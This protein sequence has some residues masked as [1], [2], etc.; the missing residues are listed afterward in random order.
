MLLFKKYSLRAFLSIMLLL[1]VNTSMLAGFS[2]SGKQL[3]DANGNNFIM[4]GVNH[5]HTWYRGETN[6]F[7]HIAATGANTVRVVLATGGRWTRNDGADVSNIINLCKANKLVCVLEVH[8][9][10][11]YTE[12]WNAT[13]ISDAVNYWTSADILPVIQGEEDYVIIN[14]ANEPYGN[15]ANVSQYVDGTKGA[16]QQLRNAG[17]TH[18]L[19]VDAANWGQDWQFFMRDN[20]PE[21]FAADSLANT[22]FDIH[23]YEVFSSSSNQEAYIQAF[24]NNNLPLVIGEFGPVH[25]GQDIDEASIMR[26]AKQYGVGYLAWSWSGNG[27]CCT[28]LDLVSNFNPNSLTTWGARFIDGTDGIRQTSEL[29]TVYSSAPGNG[30]GDG[31]VNNNIAP[32]AAFTTSSTD[33]VANFVNNSSDPDSGP[34]ALSYTWDFGDGQSSTATNPSHTYT[35]AGT[36]TITLA[37]SDGE[38]SS[39][40]SETITVTA[41]VPDNGGAGATCEYV[42]QNDW[43]SGFVAEIR[44]TNTSSTTISGWDVNWNYTDST[45]I[46]SSWNANLNGNNPY[47]ASDQGWN[48]NI[49]PNQ[50]VSFGFVG[51]YNG[52]TSAVVVSGSVCN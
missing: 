22:V 51:S 9:S 19:M 24:Q 12:Q 3:L 2:V 20:A 40:S 46:S 17:L 14:I 37:T 15:N 8:D 30:G 52:S 43:G 39:T 35:S 41:S 23:M 18:T 49:A 7:E 36:Y 47:S 48:G 26:L 45:R 28:E 44:I 25:N 10:T 21:I 1:F 29:A 31:S 11:G 13:E 4:R 16:I 50:T 33:L 32:S 38:A 6:A 27:T 34:Q 42:I 5:P